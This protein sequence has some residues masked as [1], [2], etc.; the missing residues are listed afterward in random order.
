[1]RVD[2]LYLAF[3]RLAFTRL[4]FETLLANTDWNLVDRLLVYD[5]GS[6]DGTRAYLDAAI[7]GCPVDWHLVHAGWGSPVEIM[8]HYVE[9]ADSE[10]FAKI[11]N[12]ILCPPEWLNVLTGVCENSPQL[13]L[14]GMEAGRM[15]LPEDD[16][17]GSYGWEDCSHM[18]G[19]GLIKTEVLGTRRR[20]TADGR[21][22]WTQH[23]WEYK[24]VRGWVKP[25]LRVCSLDQLPFEPWQSLAAEYV[26]QGWARAWPAYFERW[27]HGYWDWCPQVTEAA[28]CA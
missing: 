26:S 12:D 23:Q 6:E 25:D 13:Q 15:G 10:W 20:M 14:L 8:N 27:M 11:D 28:S 22:G 3:N 17:D 16:W 7:G 4:T 21:F 18:G 19:V 5:D 2:L 1:M 9:H 24:P